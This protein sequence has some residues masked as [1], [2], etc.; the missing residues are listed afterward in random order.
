M[1]IP[2]PTYLYH[3]THVDNLESIIRCNGCLSYNEKQ[4][5]DIDHLNI[6]YNHIQERR[7]R[8][9]VLCGPG[10]VLHDY[11][12]FFFAPRPPMLYTINLGNV[13]NYSDGQQSLIYLLTTAQAIS[14]SECGWVFTD[15]HGTMAF[16]DFYDTY[17][18]LDEVDW[19]VMESRYW[20]DT[21]SYPDRKRRRQAEFLI[22]D[23]CP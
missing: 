3:L 17:E 22:K 4:I 6:A 15:G 10:G 21:K 8:K 13:D 11:V 14:E 9:P 23:R 1:P 12:P 18:N 2:I 5:R 7:A 19:D 20:N 16:T